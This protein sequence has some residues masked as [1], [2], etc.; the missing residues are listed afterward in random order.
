[1]TYPLLQAATA[2]RD[3]LDVLVALSIIAGGLSLVVIAAVVVRGALL[4]RAAAVDVA[5]ALRRLRDDTAPLLRDASATATHAAA[6]TASIRHD[7]ARVSSLV[8]DATTRGHAALDLAE[9]RARE[10]DALVRM[11][12]DEAT[13]AMAMAGALTRG[14]QVG[15]AALRGDGADGEDATFDEDAE[16]D[17]EE[18]GGI[19][20]APERPAVRGRRGG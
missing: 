2:A 15:L 17:E 1:M 3:W 12:Q 10:L 5:P 11:V 6:L 18:R 4:A 14:V 9:Q 20:A 16:T 19:A 8:E 13:R 7:V